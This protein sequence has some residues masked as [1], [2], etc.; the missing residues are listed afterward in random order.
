MRFDQLKGQKVVVIEGMGQAPMKATASFSSIQALLRK[1]TLPRSRGGQSRQLDHCQ[2]QYRQFSTHVSRLDQFGT[3]TL[4][5]VM[6]PA[7]QLA[8][9]FLIDE[10]RVNT[11]RRAPIFS[12]WADAK[13][14][15][16]PGGEVPKVGDLFVQTD[17]AR[18]LRRSCGPSA[19]HR[20]HAK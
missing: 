1:Q 10:L 8:D 11:L 5:E 7:I 2:P 17:L 20:R 3:K 12:Q 15:F 6:E 4:A 9:G 13:R 16:L 18:T 14:V 19:S